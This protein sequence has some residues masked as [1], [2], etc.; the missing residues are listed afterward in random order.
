[1]NARMTA[2]AACAACVLALGPP[3]RGQSALLPGQLYD[4]DKYVD[5]NGQRRGFWYYVDTTDPAG[6]GNETWEVGNDLTK[7][8]ASVPG[9]PGP[10][11]PDPR[12]HDANFPE[13]WSWRDS[14]G[15]LWRWG[16][17]ASC[18]AGASSNIL[19]YVTGEPS[20]YHEWVYENDYNGR[21]DHT[22]QQGDGT[23]D[24]MHAEGY[25]T[26]SAGASG[27]EWGS[28][29]LYE[30]EDWLDDGLVMTLGVTDHNGD[31]INASSHIITCYGIDRTH[32]TITIACSDSEYNDHINDRYDPAV[33]VRTFDFT[34]GP[35]VDANGDPYVDGDGVPFT[36]PDG[37]PLENVL[38][39]HDY[40]TGL[41]RVNSYVSFVTNDWEGSGTGGN[42]DM[43]GSATDWHDGGNWS[44]GHVP[45]GH[46]D[47][48][49]G[50]TYD[51]SRLPKVA[52][53][54]AGLVRVST[55][56]A[57]ATRLIIRNPLSHVQVT[58]T[59]DLELGTFYV[60]WGL[61]E[62]QGALRANRGD[63]YNG[64]RLWV[65]GGWA[66]I[67]QD[68]AGGGEILVSDGG[69]LRIDGNSYLN[70]SS[71][72]EIT[73]V[74]TAMTVGVDMILDGDGSAIS[75]TGTNSS[76]TV[77][78]D[79]EFT[80]ADATITVDGINCLLDVSGDIELPRAGTT[81]TVRGAGSE[82]ALEHPLDVSGTVTIDDG[83][84]ATCSFA[85]FGAVARSL[86][87]VTEG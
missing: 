42:A 34:Y 38:H 47:G 55:S 67:W 28:N 6:G 22:W 61:I 83:A 75:I 59:G 19:R 30:M 37:T 24:P 48:D 86:M 44:T 57:E 21:W 1:M 74:G 14:R 84:S 60:D 62:V 39:I 49:F 80:G 81:L 2:L 87:H 9:W 13:S 43:A 69:S 17:D 66:R 8:I 41:Y 33:A 65:T 63:L 25:D 68:L 50:S 31:E 18:W 7:H 58:P 82:L 73:G 32:R 64:G 29:P 15:W 46:P 5:A 10:G 35:F 12:G 27:G 4:Q 52:F 70:C 56:D 53:T 76:L 16:K 51:D 77:E 71:S 85:S 40:S 79:L 54:N 78:D 3:A 72:V 20:Q 26:D 23:I 45:A 11:D 36:R